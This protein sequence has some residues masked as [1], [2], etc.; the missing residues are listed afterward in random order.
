MEESGVDASVDPGV[1]ATNGF[2]V[3]LDDMM[4]PECNFQVGNWLSFADCINGVK[5]V[6]FSWLMRQNQGL[7][8]DVFLKS[9][10]KKVKREQNQHNYVVVR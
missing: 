1:G 10:F 8:L 9:K 2:V 5:A 6:K 4:V 3:E 7:L